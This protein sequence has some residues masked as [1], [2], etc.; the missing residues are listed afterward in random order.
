M[1]NFRK[2]FGK[3]IPITGYF[4][5]VQTMV[6]RNFKYNSQIDQKISEAVKDLINKLLEPNPQKRITAKKVLSHIWLQ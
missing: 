3:Y 1:I 6:A 2:P 5:C 4:E